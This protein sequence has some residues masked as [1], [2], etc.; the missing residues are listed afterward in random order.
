[1]GGHP[2]EE[3]GRPLRGDPAADGAAGAAPAETAPRAPPARSTPTFDGFGQGRR[4]EA[5]PAPTFDGFGQPEAAG[6]GLR[7]GT[8]SITPGRPVAGARPPGA[9]PAIPGGSW[10]KPSKVGVKPGRI[11]RVGRSRPG[12]PLPEARGAGKTRERPETPHMQYASGPAG[13][14]SALRRLY[15]RLRLPRPPACRRSLRPL[16][17]KR[18]CSSTISSRSS[19]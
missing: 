11:A 17:R 5:A 4:R 2:L 15:R 1:M 10:P 14:A 19:W 3:R 8:A 13:S 7:G 16:R 6:P 18:S 9:A 12:E